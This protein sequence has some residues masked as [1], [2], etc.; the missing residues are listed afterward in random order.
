MILS[1]LVYPSVF[2]LQS[3]FPVKIGQVPPILNPKIAGPRLFSTE[4]LKN[5]YVLKNVNNVQGS[6]NKLVELIVSG[7]LDFGTLDSM[8]NSDLKTICHRLDFQHISRYS[9][10]SFLPMQYRFLC[11]SG[12]TTYIW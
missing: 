12:K 7:E 11:C 2:V 8:S 10:Y 4:H 5:S 1:Y 3:Q 6:Q 9:Q